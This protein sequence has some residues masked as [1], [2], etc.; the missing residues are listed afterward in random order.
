[1]DIM[2]HE[3]NGIE[4]APLNA[5][6]IGIRLDFTGDADDAVLNVDSITLTNEAYTLINQSVAQYGLFQGIPY[7]VKLGTLTLEYFVNLTEN[8]QFSDSSVTCT[9]VKRR[10]TGWFMTQANATSWEL[11]HSKT[12]I[13]GEIK[14]PYVIVKDNQVETLITLA[15][16]GYALTKELIQAI[17]DVSEMTAATTQAATPN[18]G[19]PPSLDTGDIIALALKI[20]A[21]IIYIA[22]ITIA[23]IKVITQLI[24]LISPRVRYLKGNKVKSLLTQGAAYFGYSFS[25]T[26]LDAIPQLT[27]CPVPLQSTNLDI[28][29]VIIGN[30]TTYF[31]KHYPSAMDT[32]PN[33][34]DLFTEVKKWCNG[35]IRV[36]GNVV[37]L[38]RRDYWYTQM[39]GT[40]VNTL[41]LQDKRENSHTYNFGDMWKRYYTHY[42]FDYAD[43]NTINNIQG[44][45]SEKSTEAISTN[46]SDIVTIKGLVDLQ[47]NWSLAARKNKLNVAETVLVEITDQVDSLINTLGGNSSLSALITSKIGVMQ[48]SKQ[49]FTNTKL[50]YTVGGR[51]PANYIDYIGANAVY[52]TYHY[53]NQVSLNLKEIGS[54]TIPFS[55][56]Q[57]QQ[58]I[59]NNVV[60]DE[61]GNKLEILTFEYISEGAQA[62]IEYQMPSTLGTNTKTITIL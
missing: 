17:K 40:I 18:A 1:M 46:N 55:P 33:I 37:H 50:M 26:L 54:A 44:I 52:Y 47:Y 20:A 58:L 15:L 57:L 19:V 8:A 7:T 59:N 13:T 14:I 12:P 6:K 10:S 35:K 32:T 34:G 4:I 22:A 60:T 27:I 29:N 48:I 61:Q 56:T 24:E 41:N 43:V 23:L 3:I 31:N 25:S 39:S 30:T 11:L 51:Q 49:H 53:I 28:F 62:E 45:Q 5:D 2:K 42:L 21:Q 16:T 38:E 9:I 36:I